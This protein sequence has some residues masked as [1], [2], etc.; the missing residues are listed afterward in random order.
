[1]RHLL[2]CTLLTLLPIGAFAQ[3]RPSFSLPDDSRATATLRQFYKAT[4]LA[5]RRRG[6]A[7]SALRQAGR[8]LTT[9]R[10][11]EPDLDLSPLTTYLETLRSLE[12]KALATRDA[13][14]ALAGEHSA[15]IGSLRSPRINL[16]WTSTR[17]NARVLEEIRAYRALLER[18]LD[19][20]FQALP[21]PIRA[22]NL[23]SLS[24]EV[25]GRHATLER[26]IAKLE[27]ALKR[28]ALPDPVYNEL[29]AMEAF[30]GAAAALLPRDALA[31]SGHERIQR[32]RQARGSREQVTLASRDRAAARAASVQLPK[33]TTQDP[34]VTSLFRRAFPTGGWKDEIV[35]IRITSEWR[36]QRH[37]NT[38]KITGRRRDA[39]IGARRAD[40]TCYL[41]DFTMH[42]GR[43]GTGWGAPRRAS[44]SG[45]AIA[46]DNLR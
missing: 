40:G 37:P 25:R 12:T 33:A 45:R 28:G 26:R 6:A 29:L 20:R 19:A 27:Q 17:D 9:L 21:A 38:G 35:V 34:A 11:R 44:H 23:T 7:H 36:P 42:Q 39:A 13:S 46:C 3:E 22:R 14:R 10:R 31:T 1:M 8:A 24:L 43:Q 16:N 32:A 41:Y 4:D 30:W 15:L 5:K 18:A 2:L